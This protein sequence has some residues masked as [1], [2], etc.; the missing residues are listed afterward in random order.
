MEQTL[1]KRPAAQAE[2]PN[3]ADKT[4]LAEKQTEKRAP[5]T[6]REPV[7]PSNAALSP[8]TTDVRRNDDHVLW[9]DSKVL[10]TLSEE[11][12]RA[13]IQRL[14]Q[15]RYNGIVL[16]AHNFKALGQS[17]SPRL[18]RVL[19]IDSA[20]QWA[21]LSTQISPT[22]GKDLIQVAVISSTQPALLTAARAAGY[23]TA[24]R[25]HVDNAASLHASF[26]DGMHYDFLMVSFKDPTNIPLELVIA[27]LHKTNTVLLKEVNQDVDDAVIALGV[28]ELGSDGVLASFNTMEQFDRF[29]RKMDAQ[30]TP[31]IDIQ[32]GVID[33]ITHLGLGYRAC[34]DTTHM[35]NPDE[36]ILVG[37][38]STGGILCCPEVFHLPYMELRPFRINA[39]SVHSYVF[40]ANDRTSYISE[41]RAGSSL[42]T[43]NARGETRQIFVGRTKTEIRPLLLIEATF[44]ENRKVNIIM[45]D[46]WHVRVFSDEVKPRNVTELKAGDRVLGYATEPG[47]HVGVKVDEHIIEL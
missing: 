7:P 43:V 25:A 44:P 8:F 33:R 11:S 21:E 3:E 31:R 9:Y 14:G 40:Q 30:A 15:G 20:E 13:I 4:A 28:L 45:Q 34:I 35:F 39:A 10:A 6:P 12:S 42:T 27:E 24:W 23:R 26:H 16:Y 18:M 1:N 5:T 17:V 37:S 47:R 38:T 2:K 46:D 36:G 32:I 41:L 19:H 22:P 29:A